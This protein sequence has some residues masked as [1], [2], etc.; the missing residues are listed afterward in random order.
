M[1][2]C[3]Q[4]STNGCASGSRQCGEVL[5]APRLKGRPRLSNYG[6]RYPE[7]GHDSVGPFVLVRDVPPDPMDNS[8]AVAK[9][10]EWSFESSSYSADRSSVSCSF[11]VGPVG[12]RTSSCSSSVKKW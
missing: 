1:G 6:H 4:P 3:C 12:Q 11:A 10:D 2:T 8:P 7:G 9:I 5:R